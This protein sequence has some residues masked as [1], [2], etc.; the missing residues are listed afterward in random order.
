VAGHR[1]ESKRRRY[2]RTAKPQAAAMTHHPPPAVPE[3]QG[4]TQTAIAPLIADLVPLTHQYP[5]VRF[6]ARI[7][8]VAISIRTTDGG[9]P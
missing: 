9:V 4:A 2:G 3:A 6:T 7:D 1:K 5:G 8:G